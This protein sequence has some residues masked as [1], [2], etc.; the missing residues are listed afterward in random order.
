MFLFQTEQLEV[1][2]L[3]LVP[4]HNHRGHLANIFFPTL[5]AFNADSVSFL[6]FL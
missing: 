3:P 6:L 2:E 1:G 5:D 4:S